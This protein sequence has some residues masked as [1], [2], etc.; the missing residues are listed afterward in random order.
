MPHGKTRRRGCRSGYALL[1]YVLR[2]K[3]AGYGERI[4]SA[5]GRQL[6]AEFGRGFDE[7]SLRHMLRFAEAFNDE[8]IYLRAAETIDVDAF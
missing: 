4:I 2:L 3:R 8:T 5:L 1:A 7:K 6:S